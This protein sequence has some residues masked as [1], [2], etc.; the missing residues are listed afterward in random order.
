M[1]KTEALKQMNRQLESLIA[2]EK[3]TI[4]N[5]SNAAA[6]LAHQ[7]PDVSWAGF[8]LYDR[9][10]DH[11]VLGPFQGKP[12]CI[13]IPNGKGVCGAAFA[14]KETLIVGDVHTFK[15]HIACDADSNA[16]IVIPL[17]KD[18]IYFGVLDI[19][20]TTH[21]RF[22]QV[23]QLYLEDFVRILIENIDVLSVIEVY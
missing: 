20:S 16:E 13:R 21:H 2:G 9:Q 17:E 6:L 11:L 23:D 1:K 8:Y 10:A 7:L 14:K 5:L 4:A 18:G 3:N 19:D 12:A 15:G 22:D